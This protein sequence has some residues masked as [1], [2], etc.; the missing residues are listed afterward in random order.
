VAAL[1]LVAYGEVAGVVMQEPLTEKDLANAT[2]LPVAT[3]RRYLDVFRPDLPPATSGRIR[4]W[5]A[6]CIETLRLIAHLESTGHS[7]TQI[8]SVLGGHQPPSSLPPDPPPAAAPA[9]VQSGEPRPAVR[10]PRPEYTY[11]AET[12]A[13]RAQLRRGKEPEPDQPPRASRPWWAFWRR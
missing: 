2:G 1:G 12:A 13:L 5:D 3:V 11:E 4:R 9:P 6:S 10:A 7:V 8:E